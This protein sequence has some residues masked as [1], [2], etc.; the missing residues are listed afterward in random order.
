LI[1]GVIATGQTEAE[2]AESARGGAARRLRS[3]RAR[4]VDALMIHGQDDPFLA[5]FEDYF[6]VPRHALEGLFHMRTRFIDRVDHLFRSQQT[7]SELGDVL[8]EH[9]AVP[10]RSSSPRGQIVSGLAPLQ[11]AQPRAR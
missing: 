3:L 6:A 11:A 8:V 4:G 7:L 5:E 10:A 9:F 2:R 1:H